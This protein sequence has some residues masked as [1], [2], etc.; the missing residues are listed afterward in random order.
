LN[1]ETIG[2]EPL[3]ISGIELSLQEFSGSRPFPYHAAFNYPG[4]K[5]VS[6][7]GELSYHEE[8]A[9]L[10]LR[11]NRL[12]V[13][14]LTLPVDGS[15]TNLTAIP[16]INLTLAQDPVDARAVFQILSVFG[17]APRETDVSG[18]MALRVTITGPSNNSLTQI[19]GLFKGVSIAGRRAL[20]GN[21]NG[22]IFLKLPLGGEPVS[23]R[24]QGN[25][26]L[27]ASDGELTNVDLIKK[28]QRITGMIGLTKE[29]AHQATTFK[30]IETDFTIADG[31]AD[32]KRIY[33]INPQMEVQGTGTMT[34][35]QPRLNLALE[36]TLSAE[37]SARV[38]RGKTAPFFKN[39]EGR[40]V[41]PLRVTG[42]VQNPS[43]NLDTDKLAEKGMTRSLEKN[44]GSFLNRFFRR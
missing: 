3:Q 29:E 4:L 14:D 41:V 5:S 44:L 22:E 9:S 6:L 23:R 20:K 27:V 32:F 35:N 7:E 10:T 18:P 28:I 33:L 12:K 42:P 37:A 39:S 1:V 19:R 11:D 26:K 21:L 17:L 15:L 25:G 8:Q 13:Q 31:S 2:H 40:I 38:N 30:T 36:T 16:R 43:V 24:L 34:L